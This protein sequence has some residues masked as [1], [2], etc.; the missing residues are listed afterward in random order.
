MTSQVIL[1]EDSGVKT[2]FHYHLQQK[3]L[4]QDG[5]CHRTGLCLLWSNRSLKYL[6]STALP[7]SRSFL[8]SSHQSMNASGSIQLPPLSKVGYCGPI[9]NILFCCVTVLLVIMKPNDILIL[10]EKSVVTTP[11]L[12]VTW[13]PLPSEVDLGHQASNGLED[14]QLTSQ[15]G[16]AA[17]P[18][19]RT[20]GSAEKGAFAG[21]VLKTRL[22]VIDGRR[23]RLELLWLT[24]VI[25]RDKDKVTLNVK[26]D[27][28]GKEIFKEVTLLYFGSLPSEQVSVQRPETHR[29]T[30]DCYASPGQCVLLRLCQIFLEARILCIILDIKPAS[31][32]CK[33]RIEAIRSVGARPQNDAFLFFGSKSNPSSCCLLLFLGEFI[34]SLEFNYHLYANDSLIRSPTQIPSPSFRLTNSITCQVGDAAKVKVSCCARRPVRRTEWMESSSQLHVL[35]SLD[36]TSHIKPIIFPLFISFT[37]CKLLTSCGQCRRELIKLNVAFL[38]ASL[39]VELGIT[40]FT[41]RRGAEF[42]SSLVMDPPVSFRCLELHPRVFYLMAGTAFASSTCQLIDC[43]QLSNRFHIYPFSY[44]KTRID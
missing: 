41:L 31:D 36:M 9:E 2:L 26:E 8:F 23:F 39:K 37:L 6:V 15:E 40:T 43:Q 29:G 10:K 17:S 34:S 25:F 12:P 44:E 20:W 35:A 1:F 38:K 28:I 13:L 33:E 3:C 19:G 18:G 11:V 7:V 21:V 32:I 5:L 4:K 22:P 42:E 14:P 30:A 16:D 27:S 24:K